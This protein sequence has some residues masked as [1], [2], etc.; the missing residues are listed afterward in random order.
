MVGSIQI[1]FFFFL[2]FM[3]EPAACGSSQARGQI[4]VKAASLYHSQTRFELH[5][6]PM[7]QLTAVP[8]P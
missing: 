7:P 5:L 6:P 8:D 2:L 1:T 4:R 3:A